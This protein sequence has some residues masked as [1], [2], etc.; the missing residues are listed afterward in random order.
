VTEPGVFER[1]ATALETIATTLT[2][3]TPSARTPRAPDAADARFEWEPATEHAP[4]PTLPEPTPPEERCGFLIEQYTHPLDRSTIITQISKA[5]ASVLLDREEA[6]RLAALGDEEFTTT[7][8]TRLAE[9][10]AERHREARAA[11]PDPAVASLASDVSD[12]EREREWARTAT[13]ARTDGDN[14][15]G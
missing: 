6:A 4:L 1:I 14:G 2:G 3:E 5:G 11:A 15:R 8:A 13:G 7:M 10:L 9:V 12:E